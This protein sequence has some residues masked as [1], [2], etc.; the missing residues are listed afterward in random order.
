MKPSDIIIAIAVCSIVTVVVFRAFRRTEEKSEVSTSPQIDYAG[1]ILQH[2]KIFEGLYHS[3]S[4]SVEGTMNSS[5]MQSILDEFKGRLKNIP[6]GEHLIAALNTMKDLS[7][8]LS[9]IYELFQSAGIKK[10]NEAGEIEVYNGLS[11]YYAEV[12][13]DELLVGDR[14]LI[15]RP[16]WE[17]NHI[18]L[19][20]GIVK[21]LPQ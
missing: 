14:V 1:L 8:E 11:R 20:K 2:A 16:Y 13:S 17:L 4:T 9:Y 6:E 21:K 12:D 7:M 5:R 3:I 15:K 10:S 18:V 19:E